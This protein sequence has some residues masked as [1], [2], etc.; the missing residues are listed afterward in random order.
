VAVFR[1]E[2]LVLSLTDISVVF[3]CCMYPAMT[4]QAVVSVYAHYPELAP[5]VI[6][7]DGC[8]EAVF[9]RHRDEWDQ[10]LTE[11]LQFA[12][13]DPIV[14]QSD[15]RVGAGRMIDSAI[16]LL[17]Q[18]Y[19]LTVDHGIRLKRRTLIE[20]FL[21]HMPG[22]VAV[23][24][25]RVNNRACTVYGA[26]VDPLFAL[27][28]RGFIVGNGLSFEL[29]HLNVPTIK[30]QIIGVT[31]SQLLQYEAAVLERDCRFVNATWS[32]HFQHVHTPHARGKN[33]SPHYVVSRLP[34]QLPR[35]GS[36][37]KATLAYRWS[38]RGG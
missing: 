2:I 13:P 20:R 3:T 9:K 15:E 30:E 36:R 33:A 8:R 5:P 26:F 6:A 29:C 10:E 14:L 17:D 4:A 12:H 32:E 1:E 34:S 24:R 21:S 23:G 11:L 16:R 18:Q 19:V 28:D 25:K 7:V 27:F 35:P 22:P 31:T 38:T 37:P